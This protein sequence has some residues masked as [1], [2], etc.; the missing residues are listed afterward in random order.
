MPYTL[1][2]RLCGYLCDDCDEPLSGVTVR[3][4]RTHGDQPVAARAAASPK[5]TL[6]LLDDQ[7]VEAK[8]ELL[9]AEAET[10]ADGAFRFD[11]DNDAYDGG[12]VE[13]D[14]LCRTVPGGEAAEDE[15]GQPVAFSITTL[16]PEWRQ[17]GDRLVAYW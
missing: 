15:A 16:Q 1:L 4:Y 9:L 14:V 6:A 12:P 8:A 13:V 3:L 2:G 11:L 5:D 7:A 17:R 10:D